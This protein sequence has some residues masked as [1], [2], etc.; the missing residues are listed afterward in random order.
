MLK[1][2]TKTNSYATYFFN[3]HNKW[4]RFI[5][6]VQI[7]YKHIARIIC[8]GNVL[9]IGCGA[10]RYLEFLRPNATGIDHNP[11]MIEY[12]R[13]KGFKAYLPE[14]FF[15]CESNHEYYNTLLFSHILE[16]MSFDD[17]RLLLLKYLPFMQRN[18]VAVII[19][20]QGRAYYSD[21]THI[22]PYDDATIKNLASTTGTWLA[23]S[24][25]F[26][27]PAILGKIFPYNDSIYILKKIA[28]N[29][30]EIN[31]LLSG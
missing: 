10:G 31:P 8:K 6:P 21:Y 28:T 29:G 17:A 27:L 15:F 1:N 13:G 7:P 9:D 24:M 18:G 23:K 16:H 14:D 20:P 11:K 2:M 22:C 19:V 5:L 3:K 12:V 30:T 26:P 4:W 25:T